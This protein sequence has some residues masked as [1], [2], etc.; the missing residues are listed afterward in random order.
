M[1]DP[2]LFLLLTFLLTPLSALLADDQSDDSAALT[3]IE[4]LGG[5]LTR[6]DAVAGRPV[7]AISFAGSQKI[8]D[9]HLRL[10]KSLP[11]VKS[12]KLN[13]TRITDAGLKELLQ[14]QSQSLAIHRRR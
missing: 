5:K 10:L 7:T 14:A 12:L 13:G 1:A 4:L 3:K 8:A 6:D 9:G 2:R 11:S